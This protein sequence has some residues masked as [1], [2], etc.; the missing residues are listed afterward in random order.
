MLLSS[1]MPY[2][3]LTHFF[4]GSSAGDAT[5]LNEG[6]SLGQDGGITQF[7]N[8]ASAQRAV[9]T[10]QPGVRGPGGF[11]AAG[12][13]Y[14]YNQASAGSARNNAFAGA[15][16]PSLASAQANRGRTSQASAMRPS[17]ERS[18]GRQISRPSSPPMRQRSGGRR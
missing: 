16:S 18:A 11:D 17:A 5:L 13:T 14:F 12:Q 2:F 9:I 7:S 4:A 3:G 8:T 10:N 1:S 15:R 6:G